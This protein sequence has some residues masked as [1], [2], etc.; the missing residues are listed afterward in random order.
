[1]VIRTPRKKM[2]ISL[3]YENTV[4]A[5]AVV[6]FLETWYC[7]SLSPSLEFALKTAQ[8]FLL[9]CIG[10]LFAIQKITVKG[11]LA[12]LLVV[13]GFMLSAVFSGVLPF[14]K[15]GVVMVAGL[16]CN[17]L[18]LYK[19]ILVTYIVCVV[20]TFML[21]VNGIIPSRIVRRGYSTYGFTHINTMALYMF[22]ILCCIV[23]LNEK[24]FC[25]RQWIVVV[26]MIFLTWIITDSRT[27]FVTMILLMILF[28]GIQLFKKMLGCGKF[29]HNLLILLP[30]IL[31]VSNLLVCWNYSSSR[32]ILVELDEQLNG[33]LYLA[34]MLMDSHKIT[35][36][37]QKLVMDAVENAYVTGLYQFG[38]I[39]LAI[40]M[41][42]YMYAVKKNL[43]S[44]S[45]GMLAC[46]IAM[47]VHGMGEG[48]TFN[49]F[50]N[51]ALLT[52]FSSKPM[53]PR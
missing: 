42:I 52:V 41:G 47:A 29:I 25:W 43:R 44:S 32:P 9:G 28:I 53:R 7:V 35:L 26:I 27:T 46:L 45:Y 33:R 13:V 6:Y 19:K 16:N 11:I 2:S 31:A 38:F 5:L 40:E 30:L 22:S 12:R 4:T 1:M 24:I 15:Y 49:P 34:R 37:G 39:P 20:I 17:A 48:A 51:V 36:F 14:L 50:M 21:S 3:N 23:I 8:F 18:K 10:F